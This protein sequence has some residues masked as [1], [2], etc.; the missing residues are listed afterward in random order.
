MLDQAST[1]NEKT[2]TAANLQGLARAPP[3]EVPNAFPL[4]AYE[5]LERAQTLNIEQLELERSIA[6]SRSTM[7]MY[8]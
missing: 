8:S 4:S 3:I 5:F 2:L 6:G 1:Q 7:A